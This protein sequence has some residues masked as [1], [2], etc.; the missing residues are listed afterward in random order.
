MWQIA[1]GVSAAIGLY[2]HCAQVMSV[3]VR[4]YILQCLGFGDDPSY[5][6]YALEPVDPP[7]W[8]VTFN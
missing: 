2:R 7:L 1:T 3:H 5:H 8:P 4:Y 6:P